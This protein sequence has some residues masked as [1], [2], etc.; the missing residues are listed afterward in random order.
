MDVFLVNLYRADS[1]IQFL[2]AR[3]LDNS[4]TSI[5]LACPQTELGVPPNSVCE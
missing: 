2:S 5:V 4:L 1:T 3:E